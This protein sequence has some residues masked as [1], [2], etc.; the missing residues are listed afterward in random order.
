MGKTVLIVDDEK[1]IIDVVKYNL[2]R[3]GY[4]VLSAKSGKQASDPS[5][6]G[7]AAPP[8]SVMAELRCEPAV[9]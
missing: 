1:D 9:A 2:V 3:E 6:Q 8:V 7:R 4:S 5:C